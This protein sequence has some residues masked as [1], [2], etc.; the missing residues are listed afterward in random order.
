MDPAVLRDFGGQYQNGQLVCAASRNPSKPRGS[1]LGTSRAGDEQHANI[2]AETA[3]GLG[4][5]CCSP[6]GCNLLHVEHAALCGGLGLKH[7][8][9][10]TA[11]TPGTSQN[12]G[13]NEPAICGPGQEPVDA[14]AKDRREAPAAARR[15]SLHAGHELSAADGGE[16]AFAAKWFKEFA[17]QQ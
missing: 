10:S 16:V 14:R 17:S 7:L 5:E 6:K 2:R 1:H 13:G 8:R 12:I 15:N 3:I 11:T 9:T 4:I